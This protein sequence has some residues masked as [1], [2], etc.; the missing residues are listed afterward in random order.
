MGA[1]I[2]ALTALLE[3]SKGLADLVIAV[4]SIFQLLSNAVGLLVEP[5]VP[6]INTLKGVLE[7][8]FAAL[9]SVFMG[10]GNAVA[11]VLTPLITAFG[12]VVNAVGQIVNAVAPLVPVFAEVTLAL[13]TTFMLPLLALV[14]VLPLLAPVLSDVAGVITTVVNAIAGVWNGIIS[15]VQGVLNSLANIDILGGHPFSGL[16]TFSAMLGAA[17]INTQLAGQA[18]QALNNS[19]ATGTTAVSAL[20]QAA[21]QAAKTL[22]DAQAS[23]FTL[24]QAADQLYNKIHGL[25]EYA[26]QGPETG[27]ALTSDTATYNKLIG[28]ANTATNTA[29]VDWWTSQAAVDAISGTLSQ[30]QAQA[31]VAAGTYQG[32]NQAEDL[33]LAALM[34]A[35][36]ANTA[37][38]S[39]N[40]AALNLTNAPTGYSAQLANWAVGQGLTSTGGG[41][42]S[43]TQA[44][45]V[46]GQGTISQ[47]QLGALG[48]G[49]TVTFETGSIVVHGATD[50]EATAVTIAERV[51]QKIS[52]DA[53]R[54]TGTMSRTQPAKGLTGGV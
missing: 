41:N 5:L 50:A 20:G 13:S 19:M 8:L 47:Q 31:Q 46:F 40:T 25:G 53:Y 3:H 9:G 38:T 36:D 44:P 49:S 22:G 28:E 4:S 34:S 24:S 1:I 23:A 37:A 51:A 52:R 48:G 18:Q 16:A 39:A 12:P 17:T 2:G 6:V 35:T 7:P 45:G 43:F 42:A 15:A 14:A 21:E 30:A 54:R 10:I 26:G 29:S 32:G 11:A 27:N 33:V